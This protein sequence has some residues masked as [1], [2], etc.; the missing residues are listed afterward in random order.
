MANSK[1]SATTN[2]PLCGLF[3]GTFDPIHYGHIAPL[4]ETL[5][6]ADLAQITYIPAAQPPHRPPPCAAAEHRLAMTRLA[7]AEANEPKF[8]VDAI[9]FERAADSNA[10]SASYTADTL[11]ALRR[12]NPH[13]R[14]A[15][16]VGLD[17]LLGLET[18]RRWQSILDNAHIIALARPGWQSPAP[19]E[20]PRWW[21]A[22]R[23]ELHAEL[24]RFPA[25]KI[26]FLAPTPQDISATMVRARL[27]EGAD[28]R[29]LIPQS[30]ASYIRTHRLYS[31]RSAP[32]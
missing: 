15:L 23:V 12:Q 25:G 30:V 31:V 14:Y 5:R 9:E 17:A 7:I 32:A 24:R 29:D 21:Q 22:A 13:Q 3:G 11:H 26:L 2:S 1:I 28:V 19:A 8:A 6:L 10:D 18:W 27:R 20:L 4:K 16:I